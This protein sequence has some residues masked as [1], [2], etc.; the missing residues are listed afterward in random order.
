M[1]YQFTIIMCL[2]LGEGVTWG[3][4]GS[5][6]RQAGGWAGGPKIGGSWV[7]G[8]LDQAREGVADNLEATRRCDGLCA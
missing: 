2:C 7:G 8:P 5:S 3:G 1:G 6:G 4:G